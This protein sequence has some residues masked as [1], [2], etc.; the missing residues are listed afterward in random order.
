MFAIKR[1]PSLL[2]VGAPWDGDTNAAALQRLAK[3][4][5]AVALVS[6]N[7]LRATPGMSTAAP[8][9]TTFIQQFLSHGRFMLLTGCENEAQRFAFSI[10]AQVDFGRPSAATAS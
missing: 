3:L 7:A 6:H 2:F 10:G 9:D 8:L 4:A 5:T 1:A